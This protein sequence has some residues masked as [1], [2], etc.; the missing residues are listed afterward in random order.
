MT[1]ST[2][3][4]DIRLRR[5][6]RLLRLE[7]ADGSC[8]ELPFELLRVYSPSAEVRGHGTGPGTLQTGKRQVDIT[9]AEMVGNYAVKLTFSDGHDSGLFTW[10]Y[11]RDLGDRQQQ[12]WQDY[13]RRLEEQGGSRD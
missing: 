7:Y 11:L 2:R 4:I 5:K 1:Q 6:S 8:H 10:D 13:L 12:V 3:P 9:G